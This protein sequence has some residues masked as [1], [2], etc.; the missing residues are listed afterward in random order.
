MGSYI[1]QLQKIHGPWDMNCWKEAGFRLSFFAQT[2][3]NPPTPNLCLN[4]PFHFYIHD[5]VL[6]EPIGTLTSMVNIYVPHYRETAMFHGFG[7]LLLAQTDTN[8]PTNS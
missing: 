1:V 6:D 3:T 2:D 8:Q 5:L 7:Y 4:I